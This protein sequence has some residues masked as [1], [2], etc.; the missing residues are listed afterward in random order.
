MLLL[1]CMQAMQQDPSFFLRKDDESSLQYALRVFE[2][3]YSRD[4]QR[5]LGLEKLW[6]TRAPPKPLSLS[7]AVSGT[8]TAVQHAV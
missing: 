1:V 4:I 6:K 5:L 8:G 2:R 3:L 7:G